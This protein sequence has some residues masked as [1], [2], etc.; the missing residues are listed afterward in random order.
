MRNRCG[1]YKILIVDDEEEIR[2][3]II[4]AVNFAEIGFELIGSAC[5]GIEA[6]E[7]TEKFNPDLIVT[8]IKM[9]FMTGIELARS[10]R[11]IHPNTFIAFLTGYEDFSYAKEAI[12]H[13]IV[14][15]LLKPIS[16]KELIIELQNIKKKMDDQRDRLINPPTPSVLGKLNHYGIVSVLLPMFYNNQSPS[17]QNLI[18]SQLNEKGLAITA[19]SNVVVIR[20]SFEESGTLAVEMEREQFLS[21][22]VSKYLDS[23]SFTIGDFGVVILYGG[24]QQLRRFVKITAM[25]LVETARKTLGV[26]VVV[27]VSGIYNF[28]NASKAFSESIAAMEYAR[29]LDNSMIFIHD[30]ERGGRDS[31]DM[32]AELGDNL[33]NM[34]KYAQMPEFIAYLNKLEGEI[35][36]KNISLPKYCNHMVFVIHKALNILIGDLPCELGKLLDAFAGFISATQFKNE[37]VQLMLKIK[38]YFNNIKKDSSSKLCDDAIEIISK[39]YCNPDMS[40]NLLSDMLSCSSPYL[41]M[42]IKKHTGNSFV[43]ILTKNRMDMAKNLIE[44][45][46][47]KISMIAEKC[48]YIDQHYFSYSFKKYFGESPLKLRNK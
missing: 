46:D 13:N 28:D 18:I 33:E 36:S 1:M 7:M 45:T 41:S 43:S 26:D 8:D 16:A 40:L 25:E 5:N 22:V 47:M 48:G 27:G 4:N 44:N 20:L 12:K 6:L 37:F 9:P 21:Q 34:L 19:D 11:E 15:Y 32:L 35:L 14:S 10:V 42:L 31:F 30:I 17:T 23:Y 2:S 24:Y 38:E 29:S 39:D 3:A